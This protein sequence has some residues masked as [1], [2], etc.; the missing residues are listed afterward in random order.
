MS[1]RCFGTSVGVALWISMMSSSAAKDVLPA[2]NPDLSYHSLVE[3]LCIQGLSMRIYWIGGLI[4]IERAKQ[5]M[6]SIIPAGT[7]ADLEG[8]YSFAQWGNATESKLIGLWSVAPSQVEGIYSVLSDDNAKRS[9]FEKLDCFAS[10]PPPKRIIAWMNSRLGLLNLFSIVDYSSERPTY[11]AMYSSWL[12]PNALSDS[13]DA[14]LK[15]NGWR[16]SLIGR[17]ATPATF[18]RTIRASKDQAWLDLNIFSVQ[19]RSVMHMIAQ[20]AE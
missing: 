3:R 11:I 15:K 13:V 18:S 7:V 5:K 12:G 8:D 1:F 6:A 10:D 4:D 16:L 19:G 14:A 9:S 20:Q 17:D 2:L